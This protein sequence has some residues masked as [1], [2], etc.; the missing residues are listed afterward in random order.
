MPDFK[1]EIQ[2]LNDLKFDDEG[3][4]TKDKRAQPTQAN[5]SHTMFNVI[6]DNPGRSRKWLVVRAK[7]AG[8]S[9]SSSSSLVSQ[10]L[11]RGLLRAENSDAGVIYFTT[12]SGYKAGYI[13]RTPQVAAPV[14]AVPAA[15]AD[16]TVHDMLNT[17]SIVKARALYDE[18]KQIFGG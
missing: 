17:L 2:K 13:K 6:R 14:V 5:I 16:S 9:E 4:P 8:V 1:S 7:T 10:F 12:V 11:T 15:P 3:E 18:L